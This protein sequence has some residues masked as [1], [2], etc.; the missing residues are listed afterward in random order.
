VPLLEEIQD[1]FFC[2]IGRLAMAWTS[3]ITGDL[4]HAFQEA[5]VSLEQLR[6]WDEPFWTAL[7]A[8]TAAVL[9]TALGRPDGADQHLRETCDL[10]DRF[11]YAWLTA[12]SRVQLGTL[13]VMQGRPDQARKLLD[14]ALEVSLAIRIT[15]H[16]TLCLAA[17]AQLALAEGDPNALRG[18]P[19][20]LRAC[21]GGPGCAR[22]RYC[23]RARPSWP[24]RSA[25]PWGMTGSAR[26][27]QPGTGSASRRRRPPLEP[28][29]QSP[30]D[31]GR[32]VLGCQRRSSRLPAAAAKV[33]R[34]AV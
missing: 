2:A 1:P 10:A 30:R 6:G 28:L 15:R 22:G 7:A 4:D 33:A 13:A 17:F 23:G 34:G 24:S 9:E 8:Y 11:D 20:R 18:W 19:G 25:R 29:A 3:P 16:V 5:S 12:M 26:P 14:E 27:S 31:A 32:P 21:V